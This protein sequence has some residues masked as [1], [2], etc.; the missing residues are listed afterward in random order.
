MNTN[1]FSDPKESPQNL[2]SGQREASS[3]VNL[4][5]LYFCFGFTK[6]SL[7]IW[8]GKRKLTYVFVADVDVLQRLALRPELGSRTV[9]AGVISLHSGIILTTRARVTTATRS[10]FPPELFWNC[11]L[12]LSVRSH[13]LNSAFLFSVLSGNRI[14]L[15]LE[16]SP[17][18]IT[19]HAG[20]ANA[21]VFAYNLHDGRWHHLAF[22]LNGQ[23][24][25]LH[26]P[27][28]ESDGG[29]TQKLP[30]LP[31]RLNPRGTF[32]LGG[33]STLLP[34]AVPFEGAVCQFDV[35]PSAQAQQN[36]CSAI[37]RQCREN[38]TYRPVPPAL[39]PLP[40]RHT[41]PLLAHTLPPNRTFTFTPTNFL[42]TSINGAGVSSAVRMSDS[43]RPKPTST[44]PPPLSLMQTG[45]ETP[46][47]RGHLNSVT[48]KPTFRTPKSP[49]PTASKP[50]AVW[51]TPTKPAGSKPTPGKTSS[52]LSATKPSGPKPTI[53][54]PT[55]SKSGSSKTTGPKPTPPK[56]SKPATVK[57]TVKKPTLTLKPTK[58]N[59]TKNT[60][61]GAQSM[62]PNKKHNAILKPL[63]DPEPTAPKRPSPTNKKPLQ[64]KT[65]TQRSPQT[66]LPTS[67]STATP[68]LTPKKSP[69][70]PK[71]A[72]FT[73]AAPHKPPKTL[74]TPKVNPDKLKTPVHYVT[75]S[76]PRFA[77]QSVTLP[78][79]ND[80]QSFEAEPTYFSLLVGPPGQKGDPGNM[81]NY[82]KALILY[83]KDTFSR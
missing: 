74:E 33:T 53:A 2:S 47:S 59:P 21:T 39:L 67:K 82:P 35:V 25:T 7:K 68:N 9:P 24:V 32:R 52:K 48:P 66:T 62:N 72:P 16:I 28:S 64:L 57:P 41:P 49:K 80:F 13:R 73:T 14:Q 70:T 19:L 27:C 55:S 44:T 29:V 30:V 6:Y 40:S 69:P 50:G 23:S 26:S 54:R 58:I 8:R 76:T 61:T 18:K 46:L 79:F 4:L 78:A 75:P 45:L 42:W 1:E 20:P 22:V 81:D 5:Y 34:G 36:Y 15:G 77:V 51:L 11:T 3:S 43:V 71:S 56:L 10:V 63:S 31:E 83:H 37:R 38:D 60:S 17:G 65:S 12:V